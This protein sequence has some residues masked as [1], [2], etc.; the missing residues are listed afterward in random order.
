M[1]CLVELKTVYGQ[2]FCYPKCEQSELLAKLSGKRTLTK[3]TLSL[4]NQL[5]HTFKQDEK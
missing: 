2:Q 1:E 5:G 3:E 4:A